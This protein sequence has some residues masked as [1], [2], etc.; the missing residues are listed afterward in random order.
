MTECPVCK[1][2]LDSHSTI[3]LMECSKAQLDDQENFEESSDK[4]PN[5]K[6]EINNHTN[7][8]LAECI[9][10]YFKTV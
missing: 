4:C 9:L 10:A 7:Q 5:C 8:Q 2:S 6:H 3:D 1:L